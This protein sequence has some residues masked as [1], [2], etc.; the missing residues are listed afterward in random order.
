MKSGAWR[1]TIG[2][3]VSI[4]ILSFSL[5]TPVFSAEGKT[6]KTGDTISLT[7]EENVTAHLNSPLESAK[8]GIVKLCSYFV[9]T[10]ETTGDEKRELIK[11]CTGCIVS[12]ESGNRVIVTSY[13]G[14]V[15][16]KRQ[17]KKFQKKKKLEKIND[18]SVDYTYLHNGGEN[19]IPFDDRKTSGDVYSSKELCLFTLSNQLEEQEA[20]HLGEIREIERGTEINVVEFEERSRNNQY[21]YESTVVH[22]GRVIDSYAVWNNNGENRYISHDARFS[23]LGGALIDTNGYLVGINSV[24]GEYESYSISIEEIRKILDDRKIYYKSEDKDKA[25]I[26]FA[27][28][29]N[30]L[31]AFLQ[32]KI[33]E[34][35]QILA[36][37]E[38]LI[39]DSDYTKETIAQYQLLI[40][41][42]KSEQQGD[43]PIKKATE[44]YSEDEYQDILEDLEQ[45]EK[46]QIDQVTQSFIEQGQAVESYVEQV[47]KELKDQKKQLKKKVSKW[48]IAMI[49]L[50][51]LD[52]IF[53]ILTVFSVL[54]TRKVVRA[55]REFDEQTQS[56]SYRGSQPSSSTE[57]KKKKKK[58]KDK[59][60][61]LSISELI[62]QNNFQNN[63]QNTHQD[64]MQ[65]F[66][67]NNQ[68]PQSAQGYRNS[69]QNYYPDSYRDNNHNEL[70]GR[71]GMP[72]SSLS[73]GSR[74]SYDY[75]G[76]SNSY[77]NLGSYGNP[78]QQMQGG[79]NEEQ[80]RF[81]S[82]R[83][84][85]ALIWYT[86][87]KKKMIAINKPNYIIGK[88]PDSVDC[89]I[90]GN[91][92]ISRAHVTIRW[93]N[94]CYF[95]YDMN[96]VNGTFINGQRIGTNGVR[97]NPGDQ[98]KLANEQFQFELRI[99]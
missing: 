60:D 92:N 45:A 90:P 56:T 24:N 54:K 20:F 79:M 39:E 11:E 4:L 51:V 49:V 86:Q 53:A 81:Q 38:K 67:P 55:Y 29:R 84:Q 28:Y 71:S 68:F 87:G 57:K 48:F 37:A 32:Q 93:E 98:L 27:T 94:D 13:E 35:T 42:I 83:Y 61:G 65:N 91:S 33:Q 44:L 18:V 63:N 80:M 47:K 23:D 26:L 15:P 3:V 41:N 72:V 19:L 58:K 89:V 66:M 10:D 75:A 36:D 85:A 30:H 64:H 7:E 21:D 59:D 74:S 34:M 46:E 9:Y 25:L 2:S 22:T 1:K 5:T 95:V 78:M 43:N 69:Q 99:K 12:G 17:K 16:T 52:G 8:N 40:D 50:A 14:L 88:N 73:S 6:E 62:Q 31:I 76:M 82:Q 77:Q 97:I 96:S 70:P